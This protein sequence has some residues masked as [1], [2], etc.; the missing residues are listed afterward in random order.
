MWAVITQRVSYLFPEALVWWRI[1]QTI[2]P[3]LLCWHRVILRCLQGPETQ[4]PANHRETNPTH[5]SDVNQTEEECFR[6]NTYLP[7][8]GCGRSKFDGK[9]SGKMEKWS[10][11][12]TFAFTYK[13]VFIATTTIWVTID[14]TVTNIKKRKGCKTNLN[15]LD[16]DHLH[17]IKEDWLID[18][19]MAHQHRKAISAKKR[20]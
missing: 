14:I 6:I 7:V 18:C 12:H 9:I 4:E 13:W 19:F 8:F 20:C 5:V 10:V 3:C 11:G 16:D 1:P 15:K 2:S 17:C